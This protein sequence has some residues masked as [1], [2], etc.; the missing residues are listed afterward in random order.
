MGGAGL[1]TQG[2]SSGAQVQTY[3]FHPKGIGRREG[4]D[5]EK[6]GEDLKIRERGRRGKKKNKKAF[7]KKVKGTSTSRKREEMCFSLFLLLITVKNPA[8]YL[9]N[10]HKTL[11]SGEK[12]TGYGPWVPTLGPKGSQ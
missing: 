11:K 8:H 5:K 4:N 10:K 2:F 12:P 9:S 7:F 1:L 3:V 6:K